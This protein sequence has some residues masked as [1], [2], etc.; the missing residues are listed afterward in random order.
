MFN[1]IT[2]IVL[3]ILVVTEIMFV[4]RYS[5][6]N[7]R[8]DS[9]NSHYEY[10]E[11]I[12]NI[13]EEIIRNLSKEMDSL[14]ERYDSVN[15][16][17]TLISEQ[18]NDILDQY[19]KMMDVW[20]ALKDEYAH[21]SATHQELLDVWAKI[22]D[23]YSDV[24]EQYRK[25]T[26]DL[27]SAKDEIN[28]QILERAHDILAAMPT[29]CPGFNVPDDET[30][31]NRFG[32]PLEDLEDNEL[33]SPIRVGDVLDEDWDILKEEYKEEIRAAG[34]NGI[35][36]DRLGEMILDSRQETLFTNELIRQNRD[37]NMS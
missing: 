13:N 20:E 6:L 8:I 28:R 17:Y 9:L 27:N 18:N 4:V 35:D 16:I 7:N 21:I 30:L 12:F 3:A 22:E 5:K 26:N 14:E 23:R 31:E 10:F 2:I 34:K 11:S 37:G 19:H 24:Y 15:K 33:H 36:S 32:V 29:S 25:C 1:I